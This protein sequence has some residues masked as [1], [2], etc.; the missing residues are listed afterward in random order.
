MKRMVSLL[1]TALLVFA[2][3]FAMAETASEVTYATYQN[4]TN[5]YTIN[6]PED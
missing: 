2:P 6:Y 4:E 3:A 5:G 1:L